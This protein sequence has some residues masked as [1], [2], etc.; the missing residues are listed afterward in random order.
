VAEQLPFETGRFDRV[1]CQFALMFFDDRHRAVAEMARVLRPGG[2]IA[3][4]TWSGLD[5]SPG[6]ASLVEVLRR[7][8]SDEAAQSLLA[9]FTLGT[10]EILTDI[11]ATAFPGAATTRHDG[12]AR[13]TSIEAWIHTEIRGWTLAD[14]IDRATFERLLA[15]GRRVLSRFTDESGR[16]EFAAPALIAT[17]I[18]V[19]ATIE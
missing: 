4:A 9:P 7:V 12:T 5:D 13:F 6:Y 3:V 15:E 16:V 11:V 10:P 17:A 8:V 2:T 19:K 1:V 14:R 18:N